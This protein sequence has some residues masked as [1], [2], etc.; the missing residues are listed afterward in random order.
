MGFFPCFFNSEL[1]N[2]TPAQFQQSLSF[3]LTGTFRSEDEE[4]GFSFMET[5]WTLCA[6]VK[7]FRFFVFRTVS[8]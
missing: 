4:D 6:V 8:L 2:V 1:K 7:L 3:F 5:K